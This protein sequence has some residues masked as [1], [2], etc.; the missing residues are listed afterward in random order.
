MES[1]GECCAVCRDIENTELDGA[2]GSGNCDKNGCFARIGGPQSPRWAQKLYGKS[3]QTKIHAGSFPLLH[4]RYHPGDIL[5]CKPKLSV[6]LR[7]VVEH[8]DWQTAC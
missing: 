1:A 3:Y 7:G 8:L 6:A 4:H 2:Y 5:S